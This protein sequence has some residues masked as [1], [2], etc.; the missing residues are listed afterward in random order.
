MSS[1]ALDQAMAEAREL[2]EADQ[3]LIGRELGGHID[4]LRARRGDIDQ[5]IRSFNAGRSRQVD[6]EDVITRAHAGT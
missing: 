6:I 5:G 1:K 3:E 4:H 2:P